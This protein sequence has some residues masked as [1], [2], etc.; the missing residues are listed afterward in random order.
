ML[1]Q[2]SWDMPCAKHLVCS[3]RASSVYDFDQMVHRGN[4]NIIATNI[5]IVPTGLLTPYQHCDEEE[6]GKI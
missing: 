3:H 4:A 6:A 5:D 1:S 2:A